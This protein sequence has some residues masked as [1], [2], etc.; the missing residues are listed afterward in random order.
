MNFRPDARGA[1][2]VT[3]GILIVGL[4][5]ILAAAVGVATVT[6]VDKVQ[7]PP[8]SVLIEPDQQR[9]VVVETNGFNDTAPGAQANLS[10][11]FTH[12]SGAAVDPDRLSVTVNEYPAYDVYDPEDPGYATLAR[13]PAR[14]TF[15][16][17]TRLRVV[18]YGDRVYP[19][20]SESPNSGDPSHFHDSGTLKRSLDDPNAQRANELRPGDTVR[21]VWTSPSGLNSYVITE[22]TVQ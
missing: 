13:A 20:G 3:G 11:T 7:N 9:G 17:G 6:F 16:A 19:D 14:S 21:L 18:V 15:G 10:V 8:P 5:I 2:S 22:Y 4:T 1:T 12:I